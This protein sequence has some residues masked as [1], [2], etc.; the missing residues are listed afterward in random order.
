MVNRER[1][2]IRVEQTSA[3]LDGLTLS[4]AILALKE[5]VCLYGAD[6]TLEE[7]TDGDSDSDRTS[8]MVFV[9]EPETDAQM[10]RRIGLEKKYEAAQESRDRED[11]ERLQKKFG[12]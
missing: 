8:L 10:S 12:K 3:D 11:F 2:M 7:V 5:L 1:K 6:A 4:K 9:M